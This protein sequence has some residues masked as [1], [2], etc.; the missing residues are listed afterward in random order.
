MPVLSPSGTLQ[1]WAA[2][3]LQW[4]TM[5]RQNLAD[6]P[7]YWPAIATEKTSG[8]REEDYIW[9]DRLPQ[10]RAWRG[11]R[12]VTN[13]AV[14]LQR[15]ENDIFELT[16]GIKRTEIDDN[17]LGAYD[18]LVPEVARAAKV[19]PDVLIATALQAGNAAPGFDGQN[20]F[21]A[22]HPVNPDNTA[23]AVPGTAYTTQPNLFTGAASGNQ[24]GALPLSLPSLAAAYAAMTAWVGPDGVPMNL[25]PDSVVVPPQLAIPS[26][27]IFNSEFIGSDIALAGGAHGA[28]QQTNY[29]R[30]MLQ[31]IVLPY[32]SGDPTS[33]YLLCTTRAT[34]P[35]IWQIRDAPEFTVLTSPDDYHVFTHDEYLWG[36]RARGNAGYAQWFLAAKVMAT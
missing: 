29:M 4:N 5:F 21:D 16:V 13:P 28:A 20:F 11:E 10:M 1:R 19:W 27:Q 17:K 26:R 25:I 34:K 15:I 3:T 24:P 2:A 31:P 23:Q 22:A 33:Y 18:A 12:V 35:L 6:T 30:G 36:T 32:L 7:V 9:L 14:R 8:T